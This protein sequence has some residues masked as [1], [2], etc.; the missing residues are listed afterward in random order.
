MFFFTPVIS[1][2]LGRWTIFWLL[3]GHDS[4]FIRS[5][6][7]S[8]Y[9]SH[10]CSQVLYFP[11]QNHYFCVP[12]KVLHLLFGDYNLWLFLTH[13]FFSSK[14]IWRKFAGLWAPQRRACGD[15]CLWP[16]VKLGAPIVGWSDQISTGHRLPALPN[17]RFHISN[18]VMNRYKL[19]EYTCGF[20]TTVVC[21]EK[22]HTW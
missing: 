19:F 2:I 1:P 15:F 6:L 21:D 4:L 13:C 20:L 7:N 10:Q 17:C 16:I 11:Y 22:I 5:D 3:L 12:P 14:R 18:K 8:T 9:F